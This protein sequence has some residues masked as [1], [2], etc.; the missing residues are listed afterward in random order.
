[1][2]GFGSAGRPVGAPVV[3][4]PQQPQRPQQSVTRSRPVQQQ[5]PVPPQ[6][7][8]QRPVGYAKPQVANTQD[9]QVPRDAPKKR[10]GGWKV[11]LQFIIGLLVI[12]AVATAIV[13]LY[14]KYYAQ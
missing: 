1:M 13:L 6:Q 14:K 3:R 4:T 8:Q 9:A 2:D 10:D 7:R 12:I 5:R 11:V